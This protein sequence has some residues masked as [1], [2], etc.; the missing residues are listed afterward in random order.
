MDTVPDES[1]ALLVATLLQTELSTLACVRSLHR[2]FLV[3]SCRWPKLL[4]HDCIIHWVL[5]RWPLWLPVLFVGGGF[6]LAWA[7][8]L[9]FSSEFWIAKIFHGSS[10][11]LYFWSAFVLLTNGAVL[12]FAS[13]FFLQHQM[14]LFLFVSVGLDGSSR[15]GSTR[16]LINTAN[17]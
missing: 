13:F 8:P 3:S 5:R 7:V 12:D 9:I 6:P 15:F 1:T 4:L 10:L 16:S 11:V 2:L 14:G 17:L